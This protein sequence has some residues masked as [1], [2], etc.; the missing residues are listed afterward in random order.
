MKD[1]L[2]WMCVVVLRGL[3]FLMIENEGGRSLLS[4]SIYDFQ[5]DRINYFV[6]LFYVFVMIY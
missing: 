2:F 1:N 4:V 6:F 3:G 5:Y